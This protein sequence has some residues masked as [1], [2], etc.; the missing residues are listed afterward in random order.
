MVRS[1]RKKTLAIKK[2]FMICTMVSFWCHQIV[3]PW[4]KPSRTL[5]HKNYLWTF[6]TSS[7]SSSCFHAPLTLIMSCNCGKHRAHGTS[8]SIAVSP[9]EI[10]VAVGAKSLMHIFDLML[11]RQNSIIPTKAQAAGNSLSSSNSA[12][13]NCCSTVSI[14]YHNIFYKMLMSRTKR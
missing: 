4:F 14:H 8:E 9:S 5:D 13:Y 6:A 12:I 1:H 10:C 11:L 3:F 2:H 7:S